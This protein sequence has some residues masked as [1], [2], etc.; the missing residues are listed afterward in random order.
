MS[1]SPADFELYSRVTGTPLPRNPQE[2]MQMAPMV[3]HFTR[4]YARQPQQP[5]FFQETAENLGKLALLGLAGGAVYGLARQGG[6]KT[7]ETP[8]KGQIGTVNSATVD[9]NPDYSPPTVEAGP[10]FS[11]QENIS[12]PE[13]YPVTSITQEQAN[14]MSPSEL[15]GEY[16]NLANT[17]SDPALKEVYNRSA[18]NIANRSNAI[19]TTPTTGLVEDPWDDSNVS[20]MPREV[21]KSPVG[22]AVSGQIERIRRQGGGR[23][24]RTAAPGLAGGIALRGVVPG[25]SG[26]GLGVG[27]GG[28][29]GQGAVSGFWG[30]VKNLPVVSQAVE[31]LENV[32]HAGVFGHTLGDAAS[33]VF[34]GV[35]GLEAGANIGAVKLAE[36]GGLGAGVFLDSAVKDTLTAGANVRRAIDPS[37]KLVPTIGQTA[38]F[39]NN[40]LVPGGRRMAGAVLNAVS[41]SEKT[42]PTSATQASGNLLEGREPQVTRHPDVP[43]GETDQAPSR[44]GNVFSNLVGNVKNAWDENTRIANEIAVEQDTDALLDQIRSGANGGDFGGGNN[45]GGGFDGYDAY[46]EFA[47]KKSKTGG[48]MGIKSLGVD[49]D[50]NVV[51]DWWHDNPNKQTP[52]GYVHDSY[53]DSLQSATHRDALIT[54]TAN[55]DLMSGKMTTEQMDDY[56]A[57]VADEMDAGDTLIEGLEGQRFGSGEGQVSAG[58]F[59]NRIKNNQQ[60]AIDFLKMH[61]D[62]LRD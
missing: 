1:A 21:Q 23:D 17:T 19:T 36:L 29:L 39:H 32:G 33:T 52:G 42:L 22:Q 50:G 9:L 11:I 53:L 25:L 30:G 2:Q 27:E 40:V 34:H 13:Q 51:V 37:G 15:S 60:A 8:A 24:L 57:L 41:T 45:G 28:A 59:A 46:Q 61:S 6:Q 54:N 56:Q 18:D 43:P 10:E 49:R 38:D 62:S 7:P 12:S 55:P 48:G 3:H 47:P 16:R 31:G 26:G 44:G 35:P 4:N 20:V 14:A 58:K 5:N